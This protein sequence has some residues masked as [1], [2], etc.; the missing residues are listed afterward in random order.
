M[1]AARGARATT[2]RWTHPAF[3][4]VAAA[5]RDDAGLVFAPN[6]V[7]AAEDALRGVMARTGLTEQAL[8]T[9]LAS[10]DGIRQ[11]VVAA[12]TVGETYFFREPRQFDLVRE[13]ILPALVD[14]RGPDRPLRLWSAGC[15]TGEEPYSLAILLREA[16]WPH[17]ARVLGTDLDAVRLAAARRARY[18]SWSFRGVPDAIVQRWFAPQRKHLV[19]DPSIRAAVELRVLNLADDAYPSA[20]SGVF[21]MD[22]IFCRNVLIYLDDATIARI[23]TR[24]LASL[25]DDGWLLLGASDPLLRDLVDCEVV[26]TPAG[27]AYRRT[28]VGTRDS[29]L[30]GRALDAAPIHYHVTVPVADDVR[31]LDDAERGV[32]QERTGHES[33]VTPP[34]PRVPPPDDAN[35]AY[36]AGDYDAAVAL[37]ERAIADGD[38]TDA[39]WVVRVRALANQ[40]RLTEAG[41]ACAA[42]LER[43]PLS[44]NLTYLHAVLLA[45][46]RRSVDVVAAAR[47]ALYLDR[48]LAVAHLLLGEHLARLGDRA[49]AARALDNAE[50]LLAPLAPDAPVPMADGATAARL[51]H[52]ARRWR[53][54]A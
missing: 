37:A 39:P 50:A 17:P 42:A 16:R 49:G 22:V 10:D 41:E 19:L 47:R 34:E 20:A 21:A 4:E 13:T 15:A 7:A 52:V 9:S 2:V 35:A 46:A 29:G 31:P 51:R 11:Q 27:L 18:S 48:G 54:G 26:T 3:A 32:R 43:H 14:A 44:A 6:R 38:A 23:A 24:L 8:A 28:G 53:E 40:G 36:A 25:S 45:A 33:R 5:L 12:L 1:T 30:G